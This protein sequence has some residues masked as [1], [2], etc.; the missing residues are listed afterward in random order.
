MSHSLPAS[1]AFNGGYGGG[2]L[3]MEDSE[4]PTWPG[5]C[6]KIVRSLHGMGCVKRKW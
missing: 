6:Q 3:L 1:Q 4:E 2:R 5:V